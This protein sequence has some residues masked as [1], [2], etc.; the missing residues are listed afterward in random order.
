[1]IKKLL[2]A[3]ISSVFLFP[4]LP[5][6][7]T[8]PDLL[9]EADCVAGSSAH[10]TSGPLLTDHLTW[11]SKRLCDVSTTQTDDYET[12]L[13][14][15][16]VAGTAAE[17]SLRSAVTQTASC[18][19]ERAFQK[20]FIPNAESKIM[21]AICHE[22]AAADAAPWEVKQSYLNFACQH[23]EDLLKEGSAS[24][25]TPDLLIKV[26]HTC[27]QSGFLSGSRQESL[28][29]LDKA[30]THYDAY[31]ALGHEFSVPDVPVIAATYL[32]HVFYESAYHGQIFPHTLTRAQRGVNLLA[33]HYKITQEPQDLVAWGYALAMT[34]KAFYGRDQESLVDAGLGR[35]VAQSLQGVWDC[36]KDLESDIWIKLGVAY[37]TLSKFER[38]PAQ[39]SLELMSARK[40]FELGLAQQASLGALPMVTEFALL[41]LCD[42]I[43]ESRLLETTREGRHRADMEILTNCEA[44][45]QKGV[46]NTSVYEWAAKAAYNLA[47]DMIN[48]KSSQFEFIQKTVLY[49]HVSYTKNPNV[50]PE[51]YQRMARSNALMA[52]HALPAHRKMH[53]EKA[54]EFFKILLSSRTDCPALFVEAAWNAASL[55]ELIHDSSPKKQHEDCAADWLKKG[56]DCTPQKA[57]EQIDHLVLAAKAYEKI[58]KRR[59]VKGVQSM[60]TAIDLCEKA[61]EKDGLSLDH[62]FDMGRIMVHATTKSSFDDARKKEVLCKANRL[63]KE[64]IQKAPGKKNQCLPL[65][66]LCYQS[67]VRVTP[68]KEKPHFERE[69]VAYFSS[70]MGGKT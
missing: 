10:Y 48:K 32:Q 42:T 7:G 29:Y 34:M 62:L 28:N 23:Y 52:E 60:S 66:S 9:K 31:I 44:Q 53:R 25:K 54:H 59:S 50:S 18:L 24:L 64:V 13:A 22:L 16:Q 1:M 47:V 55:S 3:G 33:E 70:L 36:P 69:A 26:A 57:F 35:S 39:K 6:L 68:E 58:G 63:F 40:A 51:T 20:G 2:F 5:A 45:I 61:L 21:A 14:L 49:D 17:P 38:D 11:L 46:A 27:A 65:I 19:F 67:L 8:S 41:Y 15:A 4:C 12:A 43:H 30:I 37:L 56:A